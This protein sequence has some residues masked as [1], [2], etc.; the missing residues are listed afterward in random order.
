M[1][2]NIAAGA[3]RQ[4]DDRH[5]SV[6]VER[7]LS[8]RQWLAQSLETY[9]CGFDPSPQITELLERHDAERN[10][11]D[12]VLAADVE[13]VDANELLQ[14][15]RF[16]RTLREFQ[17]RDLGR[18]LAL[19]HGANFSVPGA[20]KTTVAYALYEAERERRGIR[21]LLVVAPCSA[22]DAW[23]TEA[24]ECL[25]PARSSGSWPSA[26]PRAARSCSSTI[27]S[28]VRR[29][30]DALRNGSPKSLAT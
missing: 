11:I 10:E 4:L 28:L 6:P 17:Q 30:T 23:L 5:V 22:F 14:G 1:G 19:S 18:L 29:D 24:D 2:R 13:P 3:A 26:R 15:S 8:A 16:Y 20:G 21:R 9:G 7:F 12:H 25:S 27:K